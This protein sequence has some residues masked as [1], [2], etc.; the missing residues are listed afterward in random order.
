MRRTVSAAAMLVALTTF[1]QAEVAG[2][3]VKIGVL[4]DLSGPYSD[5]SGPTSLDAARMAV[6][7]FKGGKKNLKVEIVTFDHQNKPDI[8]SAAAR[9][10][11]DV[12]GV[13]AIADMTNSGVAI[14]VNGIA[15]ERG[16]V[17][18]MT[19]PGTTALTNDACSPTGFHWG[20]DTYSQSVG[21]AGAVMKQGKDSWYLV[22]ADYAFGHQ[23]AASI[24]DTVAANKGKIVG[25]SRHPLNTPD[26]SSFILT[27]QNSGAKVVALANGGADT[28]NAVKQAGEFGVAQGGQTLAA[29]V[30][31]ISD[32]H[33]LGLQTAQGLV[34]TTSFYH[35]R[36]EA[37]RAFSKRFFERNKRMPGMIQAATYSSV[38]HYLKAIDAADS[39]DGAT[40]A[41]KMREMPVQ[42]AFSTNGKIRPDG[43]MVTDMYLFEVKK[44]GDSKAPW[45]YFNILATIPAEQTASPLDKSTCAQVKK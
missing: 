25:E 21:T 44:P 4:T 27:A 32:V 40:V 1:A 34:G 30:V 2:G 29:L 35:D 17:T 45:D 36:D 31:V 16:K 26:F 15:K 9:R 12:E 6:E 7:D 11:F 14:A 33:A 24:R 37:S 43:R 5:F 19:G 28:I 10:W 42:D 3:T 23:M 18:L 38:L 20:W 41:A 39:K 13:D 8:A 22:T